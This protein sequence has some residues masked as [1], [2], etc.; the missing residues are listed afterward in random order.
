MESFTTTCL[1]LASADYFNLI[2]PT[3]GEFEWHRSKLNAK[4]MRGNRAKFHLQPTPLSIR[5]SFV[6]AVH[7]F[8]F[9]V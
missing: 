5:S 9:V 6:M 7:I 3:H 8:E 2:F 4:Q 1:D